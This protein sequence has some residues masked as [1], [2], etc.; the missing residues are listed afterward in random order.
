[1]GGMI[2]AVDLDHVGAV[3]STS[4]ILL[5]ENDQSLGYIL[6]SPFIS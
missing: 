2:N 5:S 1:M 3:D 6:P 4:P